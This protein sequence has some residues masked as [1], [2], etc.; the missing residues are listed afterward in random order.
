MTKQVITL[1]YPDDAHIECLIAPEVRQ[2][3]EAMQRLGIG[4]DRKVTHQGSDHSDSQA[5]S[6]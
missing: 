6:P 3:K 4:W 5:E 2:L 1:T